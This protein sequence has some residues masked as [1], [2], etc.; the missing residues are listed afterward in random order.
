MNKNMTIE[1]LWKFL[2]TSDLGITHSL[3]I[4]SNQIFFRAIRRRKTL[5]AFGCPIF[6][7]KED[8]FDFMNEVPFLNQFWFLEINIKDITGIYSLHELKYLG[9]QDKRPAID[10]LVSKKPFGIL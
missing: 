7:F 10:F 6:G 8:N 4:E 9:V 1:R 2:E 3:G 5:G